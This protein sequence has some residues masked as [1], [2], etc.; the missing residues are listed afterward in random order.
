MRLIITLLCLLTVCAADKEREKTPLPGFSGTLKR[1]D[2]KSLVLELGDFRTLEFRRTAKTR[3]LE[4]KKPFDPARLKPGDAVSVEATQDLEGFLTAVNVYLEQAAE[5]PQ[6]PP[7]PKQT[8][9]DAGEG[10]PDRPVLRR[11]QPPARKS[12]EAV[13]EGNE[14]PVEPPRPDPLILRAR[15]AAETF[16]QS[17][18]NYV[19][20]QVMARFASGTRADDW[21][22]QDVVTAEVVYENG[23]EDYRNVQINGK[24]VKR[25]MEELSGSW[26]TG[27]FGSILRD[28]FSRSTAARFSLRKEAVIAGRTAAVYGYEVERPNSHWEVRMASQSVRPAYRGAVWIDKETGRTLRIEMEA[29]DLPAAFPVDKAETTNDY[30]FVRLGDSRQY[31]LPVRAE[32]LTCERGTS[33]CAL[34]KI[35]FRNYR[36]YSGEAVISYDE[37]GRLP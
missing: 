31:L 30:E 28:L 25:G 32:T 24:T 21:K 15:A 3:F 35:D 33:R 13:P 29:A 22:A 11:G 4:R 20:R 2:D 14:A 6:P 7:T 12:A 9:R 1:I 26:S 36:K 16:S 10:D 17:L 27:E 23:R 19:C 34:N 5:A 37:T 8:V 18:P